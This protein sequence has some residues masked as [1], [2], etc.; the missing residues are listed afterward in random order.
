MIKNVLDTNYRV[1]NVH[2]SPSNDTYGG[3]HCEHME[4]SKML[5]VNEQ[6]HESSTESK[7]EEVFKHPQEKTDINP[8]QWWFTSKFH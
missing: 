8:P 5:G 6:S 1:D 4:F 7:F 2:P 3:H